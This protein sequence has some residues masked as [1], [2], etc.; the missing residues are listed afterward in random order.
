MAFIDDNLRHPH[1]R[2][3]NLQHGEGI[4]NLRQ[5]LVWLF[6]ASEIASDTLQHLHVTAQKDR[7]P[8]ASNIR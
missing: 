2:K 1:S 3:P 6:N 7:A 8:G 5:S 4:H